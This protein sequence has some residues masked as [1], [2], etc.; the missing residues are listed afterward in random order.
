MQTK[1]LPAPTTVF[2]TEIAPHQAALD[3]SVVRM[4][5]LALYLSVTSR[6]EHADTVA[7]LQ[8]TMSPDT[9][10][11]DEVMTDFPREGARSNGVH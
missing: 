1:M 8:R 7:L 3:P 9:M 4:A 10:S 6:E 11:V 5:R 2:P